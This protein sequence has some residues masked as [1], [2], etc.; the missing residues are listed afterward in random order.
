MLEIVLPISMALGL[1]S[2]AGITLTLVAIALGK[3]KV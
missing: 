1:I 2:V 3:V